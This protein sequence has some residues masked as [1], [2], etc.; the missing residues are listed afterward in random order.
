MTKRKAIATEGQTQNMA[1]VE[2]ERDFTEGHAV[3]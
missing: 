1:A 2:Q 3:R